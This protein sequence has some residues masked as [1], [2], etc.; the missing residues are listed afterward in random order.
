MLSLI[1]PLL[2][3]MLWLAPAS[4]SSTTNINSPDAF[5]TLFPNPDRDVD[6][7]NVWKQFSIAPGAFG[8][9]SPGVG[10]LD[11]VPLSDDLVA[12]QMWTYNGP[13]RVLFFKRTGH[14]WGFF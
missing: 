9:W 7:V 6:L 10:S 3:I 5:M 1:A 14:D 13:C 12:I 2:G 11:K 8:R 4:Q